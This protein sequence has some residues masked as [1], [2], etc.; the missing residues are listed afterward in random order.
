MYHSRQRRLCCALLTC[1]AAAAAAPMAASYAPTVYSLVPEM[2]MALLR[3]ALGASFSA[4]SPCKSRGANSSWLSHGLW[5][6]LFG[7]VGTWL[8]NKFISLFFSLQAL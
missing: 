3:C 2:S 1:T 4:L 8:H 7:Q 5:P 6:S